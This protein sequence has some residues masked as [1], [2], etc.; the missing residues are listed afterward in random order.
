LYQDKDKLVESICRTFPQLRKAKNEFE[1]G[2]KLGFEG[3]DA[4]RSEEIT[5]V[6]PKEQK[7]VMDNIKNI[8]S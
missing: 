4:E 2:Y 5:V 1:F 7:G 6:E 8:F 3:L